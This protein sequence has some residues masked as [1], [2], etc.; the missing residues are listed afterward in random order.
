MKTVLITGASGGIGYE[1]ALIFARNKYN[2]VLVARSEDKLIELKNK[3]TSEI[4]IS[5]E[6][7]AK[8][9]SILANIDE[10]YAELQKKQIVIDILINNAGFGD[11][12]YFY[13][14]NWK[15]EDMMLN[16]NIIS[17]TYLTKLF[18]P[19]MIENKYGKILNLASIAAFLPG[20][21]MA[22]YYA[23]K[24]YVLSFSSAIANE[25]KGTGVTVTSLCPGPTQSGFS[26]A[27]ALGES[28]L[29]KKKS[30]P[31]AKV[32]AEYGYK[33]L[34]K[35][36][37]VAVHGAFNKFEVFIMRFAPRKLLLSTIRNMQEKDIKSKS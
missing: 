21:L 32:V 30:L 6:V 4:G 29:F 18:L 34:M 16:L 14:T 9:I 12:G 15:K 19:K 24:A 17:L 37:L 36:K 22:I 27:A 13:Q 7:F 33:S 2:L 26:D 5:V 31:T 25:L 11:Y 20:P 35:G 3:L 28:K 10:L 1:F 23:T 8:D